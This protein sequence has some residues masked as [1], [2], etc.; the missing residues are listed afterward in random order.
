M[1][2]CPLQVAVTGV[3]LALAAWGQEPTASLSFLVIRD[4]NGK[5]IR[6]ASVVLHPVNDKGKQSRGGFELKT[7]DDGKTSFDGVPYGKLRVQVLA[8]GFQ[9]FGD[10]YDIQKSAVEI[11][12]KMRR[13]QAQYSIY[14]DSNHTPSK[15]APAQKDDKPSGGQKPQ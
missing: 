6:N 14:P 13:P 9:T 10:D 4:Y 3:L 5:P 7:D 11:T 2:K 15:D 12:I 1:K 8:N